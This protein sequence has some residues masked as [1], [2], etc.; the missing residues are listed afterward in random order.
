MSSK[1]QYDEYVDVARLA[2]W[3]KETKSGKTFLSGFAELND[4][5]K[6][7][8]RIFKAE[9]KKTE[10]SPDYFGNGSVAEDAVGDEVVLEAYENKYQKKTAPKKLRKQNDDVLF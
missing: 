10:T 5:T 1:K 8:L 3:V 9:D 6:I 2:L 4:G 7:N